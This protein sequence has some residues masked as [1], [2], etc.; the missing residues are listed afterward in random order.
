MWMVPT[1]ALVRGDGLAED[2]VDISFPKPVTD[3]VVIDETT[4][5]LY[6]TDFEHSAIWM[7]DPSVCP[8]QYTL[9]SDVP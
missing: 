3:G 6:A 5:L 2:E 1:K 9:F 7:A 4:G 8:F